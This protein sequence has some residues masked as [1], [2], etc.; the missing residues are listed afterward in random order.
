MNTR[1]KDIFVIKKH[2]AGDTM[3]LG[4]LVD[5]GA[6]AHMAPGGMFDLPVNTEKAHGFG[7]AD[8]TEAAYPGANY[9]PG[10]MDQNLISHLLST[11]SLQITQKRGQ[12]LQWSQ[13]DHLLS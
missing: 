8:G 6:D 11:A 12:L 7:T 1:R 10:Y 5:P 9:I 3:E 2:E 13:L 4:M